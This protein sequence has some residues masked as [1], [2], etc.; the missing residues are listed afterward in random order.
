MFHRNDVKLVTYSP[1]KNLPLRRTGIV[2]AGGDVADLSLGFA[3]LLADRGE[4]DPYGESVSSAPS[5]MLSFLQTGKRG[6]RAAK[7]LLGA[8]ESGKVTAGPKGEKILHRR[9]EVRLRSPVTRPSIRDF[10]SFRTHMENSYAKLGREIPEMWFNLPAYYRPNPENVIGAEDEVQWPSFTEKL[11]YEFE[12]AMYVGKRAKNV[13]A[14]Q[15]EAYI[16]GFSIF[17]DVSARDRQSPQMQVGVG[18]GKGKDFDTSKVLGPYL[19]TPDEVDLKNLKCSVRINGNEVSRCTSSDMYWSWGDLL[20]YISQDETIYPGEVFGSGT[21]GNGCALETEEWVKPGDTIEL[22][23]GALGV[24]R[25]TFRGREDGHP[26]LWR[27]KY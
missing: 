7:T 16:A 22:D 15:A 1:K 17:N 24:L 3:G 25:N 27:E 11:D 9:A 26:R 10:I 4:N 5:D 8:V 14:S 21:M 12:I 2:L 23:G 18:P 6:M 13:R 20:E 19:V